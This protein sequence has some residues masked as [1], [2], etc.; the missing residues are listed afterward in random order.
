MLDDATNAECECYAIPRPS[1]NA[2]SQISTPL[3]LFKIQA[4]L[5]WVFKGQEVDSLGM[6]NDAIRDTKCSAWQMSMCTAAVKLI[7]SHD[8]HSALVTAFHVL[9]RT[10][11]QNRSQLVSMAFLKSWLYK[12]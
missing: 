6:P 5:I 9:A 1:E 4:Q 10:L 3:L 7:G 2:K 11:W 8:S 12:G